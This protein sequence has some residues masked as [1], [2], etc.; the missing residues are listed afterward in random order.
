MW[1]CV[2]T[3]CGLVSRAEISSE[4]EK[5]EQVN[6]LLAGLHHHMEVCQPVVVLDTRY[7]MSLERWCIPVVILQ[8]KGEHGVF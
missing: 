8:N 7:H 3:W 2:Y 5:R 4:E 6:P 1:V